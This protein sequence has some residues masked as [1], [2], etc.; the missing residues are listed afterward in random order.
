[1]KQADYQIMSILGE[2][3]EHS[4]E[5]RAAFLDRACAGDT[6]RR[7]RVEALLRAYQ[8]AGNFMQDQQAA[9]EPTATLDEPIAERPGTMIGS[10][11]L[12][13]QIGEG[14]FGVVFMAEQH[15]P[16]RRKVALKVLKPGMDTRQVVARIEAE[17]QALALMDHPN[18]A[19]VLDGGE[20]VTGRPYFVMELVRGIPITEFCDQNHLGVRERLELFLSMCQAV[21]HAHQKGIIH[22]DI[23]PTN[24]LVTLHDNR[25]VVKVIDFGIAKATGQQLTEKTLFTNFAQMIG[26]PLYMS[27]EQAQMSGLDIDTRT[28]IY[29]LGVLLYELLTGTTPLDGE[30]LRTA[31]Y[32]EIRRAIRE[33]E[34]P[35]PSTRISTL[36]QAAATV[37]ANRQS[38]PKKLSKFM[39]GELDWIVMKALE[40]DRNRRY[41]SA[42]ALASD[43]QRYLHDEPVHAHPPSA[44][45]RMG[46]MA[47]RKKAA[48]VVAGSGL[49][50]F[51]SL[52]GSIGWIMRD[53]ASR[54]EQAILEAK[55]ALDDINQLW[56]D[57]KWTTALA[58]TKRAES[59]LGGLDAD[60][61]LRQQFIELR[62]DLE[63]GGQLEDIRLRM[64]GDHFDQHW[65]AE[66]YAQAFRD[67][68]ID[69][70]T[71]EPADMALRI[72]ERTI[73]AELA[74]SLDDWASLEEN[75]DK[76]RRLKALIRLLAVDDPW[77]KRI[78][79]IADKA[80]QKAAFL[81][82]AEEP[83]TLEQPPARLVAL[84]IF[85]VRT[86]DLSAAV[87]FMKRAQLRHPG[88]FWINQQLAYYLQIQ[89]DEP[90]EAIAFFRVAVGLR[91]QS[92]A[93]HL[94]LG[95]ILGDLKKV[96]DAEAE[97]REAIK[98]RPN[99]A[100]AHLLLAET[101]DQQGK[102]AEALAEFREGIGLKP[103]LPNGHIRLGNHFYRHG[104]FPEAIAE[105][106][107]AARLQPNSAEGHR[108]LGL[109]LAQTGQWR[110]AA[111]EFARVVELDFG[112]QDWFLGAAVLLEAGDIAGYRRFCEEMLKR[113][114]DTDDPGIAERTA[115]TC[116]LAPDAVGNIDP[117][118]KLADFALEKNPSDRW[119]LLTKALADYR[120]GRFTESAA[121][122]NRLS[123]GDGGWVQEATAYA[124]LAMAKS[125]S[126]QTEE[127]T[128]ALGQ[129]ETILR[130]LMTTTEKTQDFGQD[131]HNWLRA[132][133]LHREAQNLLNGSEGKPLKP[134]DSEDTRPKKPSHEG[135]YT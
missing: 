61:K 3:V 21:Q 7:A 108:R 106:R 91:P 78:V 79:D 74:A 115:K 82:M 128:A 37:S 58:V 89:N 118:L 6:E 36:G 100:Q 5:E 84:G 53:R 88:D 105:F 96:P 111:P 47:R 57:G 8:N 1:V 15:Q 99:Y 90:G 83:A 14:G 123:L 56:R 124:I 68:G 120:A 117:V 23:K 9:A 131:W 121:W 94:N 70:E 87:K 109:V 97:F 66:H 69:I 54:H 17:R 45:Y 10:Y 62:R 59:Q 25:P 80:G 16:V 20:T 127:A 18:I 64:R 48:L 28:D 130:K 29:A 44:W 32:D 51:L 102:S 2:A 104:N 103:D 12:L 34:P 46:K 42:S 114:G 110:H 24:V 101:L 35:K 67:F 98:L 30:R 52:A 76:S 119:I 65:R 31:G 40:K 11:K 116:L 63:M 55:S 93:A 135:N 4:P 134:D 107:E 60:P 95:I 125:K 85:L 71:L 22:R 112:K 122:L 13:E 86:G 43:V 41:E 81:H 133:I 27:P 129:A 39:R 77:A 50:V 26:T 73:R 75:Q 92:P 38:D 19:R 126:G 113:F 33:E 132:R 49:L 72:R